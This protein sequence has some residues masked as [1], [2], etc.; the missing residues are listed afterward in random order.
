LS[1]ENIDNN[2]HFNA[3]PNPFDS[4]INF[5]M[6]GLSNSN[7]QIV[8]YDIEGKKVAEKNFVAQNTFTKIQ[9]ETSQL[10]GASYIYQLIQNNKVLSEGKLIRQ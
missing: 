3:Y 9:I 8:I 6:D 4:Y 1:I 10:T 5:S 2:I 7:A